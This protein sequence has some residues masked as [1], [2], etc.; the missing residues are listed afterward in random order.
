MIHSLLYEVKAASVWRWLYDYALDC[1]LLITSLI[2]PSLSDWPV[3]GRAKTET[4]VL[5][6]TVAAHYLDLPTRL[7]APGP[8]QQ[9]RQCNSSIA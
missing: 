4:D 5:S 6:I 7:T 1:K 8:R 3:G 9:E 2:V